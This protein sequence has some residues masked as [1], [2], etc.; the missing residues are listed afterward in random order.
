MRK[1]KA[2]ITSSNFLFFTMLIFF[3]VITD[4][5]NSCGDG[6]RYRK[7]KLQQE[8]NVLHTK[9]I[10]LYSR[11]STFKIYGELEKEVKK[12]N[13]DLVRGDHPPYIIYTEKTKNK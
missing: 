12:R 5:L 11:L 9:Y 10:D 13:L 4:M 8:I 3:V 6:L 2:K 1:N 7:Y